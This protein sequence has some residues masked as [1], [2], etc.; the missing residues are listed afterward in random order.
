[1]DGFGSNYTRF[2]AKADY[3]LLNPCNSKLTSCSTVL[4]ILKTLTSQEEI[5]QAT[6]DILQASI[7]I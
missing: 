4:F 1:M 6:L 7:D 5:C 2:F 3:L